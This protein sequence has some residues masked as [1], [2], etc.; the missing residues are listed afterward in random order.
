MWELLKDIEKP[1]EPVNTKKFNIIKFGVKQVVELTQQKDT[2]KYK[3]YDEPDYNQKIAEA[4]NL[5][6]QG[7]NE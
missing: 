2:Q 1:E 4:I 6:L 5:V 3:F 7:R